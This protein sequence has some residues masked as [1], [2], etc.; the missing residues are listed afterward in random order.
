MVESVRSPAKFR[1]TASQVVAVLEAMLCEPHSESTDDRTFHEMLRQ[2]RAAMKAPL[3]A[4]L[5]FVQ[6]DPYEM[7]RRSPFVDAVSVREDRRA[8]G[9]QSF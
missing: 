7:R 1:L 9:L 4:V 8:R 5:A 6:F 2:V 3:Y